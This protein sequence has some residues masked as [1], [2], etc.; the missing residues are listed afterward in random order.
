MNRIKILGAGP[1]GLSAAI[2][3]A[4]NGYSVEVYEKNKD[5]GLRFKGDL[6]GLENWSE[7]GEV[8][9]F[10]KNI[11]IDINFDFDPFS[12]LTVSNGKKKW[13]FS[14]QK[15]A[16]FLVKRGNVKGSLDN[17]LKEQAINLG[18]KLYFEKTISE[19]ESDII[20]TGPNF[21]E[22]FAIDKGI[23]FDTDLK[24]IAVGLANNRVAYKGYSYLL[25]TK[26]YGCM[27]SFLGDDFQR[28]H[29]CFNQTKQMFDNLFKFKIKNPKEVGGV[30]S[31]SLKNNFI[32]NKSKVVGEAAGLQ[33]LLWGFGIRNALF[34]GYL[35]A[36]SIVENKDYNELAKK[37]FKRRL[38]ASLVNRYFWEKFGIKNYDY[39]L[40]KI[41]NIKDPLNYLY[42]FYNYNFIQKVFYPI[43]INYCRKK[44]KILKL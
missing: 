26:G 5:V 30:G 24:D 44:Y 39:I 40:G 37:Y 27:C 19:T 35:A 16:F 7:K 32:I 15:P 38:K 12:E 3:L 8:K 36:K 4:K 9:D 13:Q 31:F 41:H 42:S 1:S 33:D 18:I 2:N 20:A 43:A 28:V 10:L 25:V 29:T 11:N 6:Q 21:E 23:I 34:S 17:G 14:C 22:L